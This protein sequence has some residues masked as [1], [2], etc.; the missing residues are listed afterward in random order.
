LTSGKIFICKKTLNTHIC[1]GDDSCEAKIASNGY[2]ICPISHQNFGQVIDYA[3]TTKIERNKY[4]MPINAIKLRD[5]SDGNEANNN[6]DNSLQ[7]DQQNLSKEILSSRKKIQTARKQISELRIFKQSDIENSSNKLEINENEISIGMIYAKKEWKIINKSFVSPK[8]KR[9]MKGSN[10]Y[11]SDLNTMNLFSKD[12]AFACFDECHIISEYLIRFYTETLKYAQRKDESTIDKNQKSDENNDDDD[13][14]DH[15][16]ASNKKQKLSEY[17]NNNSGEKTK[18]NSHLADRCKMNSRKSITFNFCDDFEKIF[19]AL[20]VDRGFLY[21][22]KTNAEEVFSQVIHKFKK[23]MSN[24]NKIVLV[25]AFET[26]KII[27]VV[28]DIYSVYKNGKMKELINYLANLEQ[29][30]KINYEKYHSILRRNE[31][32]EEIMYDP[33]ELLQKKV[34]NNVLFCSQMLSE[35]NY[36]NNLKLMQNTANK[37]NMCKSVFVR[38]VQA[39]IKHNRIS[40]LNIILRK[41]ITCKSLE[42]GTFMRDD[43]SLYNKL[44]KNVHS[45]ISGKCLLCDEKTVERIVEILDNVWV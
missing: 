26:T 30:E 37:K 22:Y 27:V 42:D 1:R 40:L 2:Y 35:Q 34:V 29:L 7:E 12:D 31:E 39:C 6:N 36:T 25:R 4:E 44:L 33:S 10:I 5:Q 21:F 15:K 8:S 11:I 23:L 38:F 16:T 45:I 20:N 3:N 43:K 41:S 28:K 17:N 32:E 14:N 13:G 24:R 19:T 9:K 18:S